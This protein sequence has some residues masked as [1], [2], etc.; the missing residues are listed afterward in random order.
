[1]S[2]GKIVMKLV[3]PFEMT[4]IRAP[5]SECRN[6]DH[7]FFLRCPQKRPRWAKTIG[8][9]SAHL[10]RFAIGRYTQFQR[11]WSSSMHAAVKLSSNDHGDAFDVCA[12][13]VLPECSASAFFSSVHRTDT[14]QPN[15][16]SFGKLH[17]R[18]ALYEG[19]FR[20]RNFP[21]QSP[22][23]LMDREILLLS[24]GTHAGQ[25]DRQQTLQ[26]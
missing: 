24:S 17:R 26:N 15:H 5:T 6:I 2:F 22:I 3:F 1:M 21:N 13:H 4:C 10:Q 9:R 14:S 20:L 8:I 16:E 19:D 11:P 12:A 23:R 25:Q 7:R 18:P